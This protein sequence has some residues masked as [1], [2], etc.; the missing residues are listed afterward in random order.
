MTTWNKIGRALAI[1]VIVISI[2]SILVAAVGIIGVWR[3]NG[4]LTDALVELAS[5]AQRGLEAATSA[6]DAVD[7]LLTE[8]Q[9]GLQ[10]VQKG[11]EELKA[12]IQDSTPIVAAL[13]AVVGEDITPKVEEAAEALVT[14]RQAARDLNSAALAINNLPFANIEGVVEATQTFI[15][16]FDGIES[17]IEE[18]DASVEALKGG[19]IEG[20][21]Q[22]VQDLAAEAENSLAEVQG[23]TQDLSGRLDN[24]HETVTTVKSRIPL[25]IDLLSLA[26]TVVLLWGILAQAALIYLCLL[27]RKANRLDLHRALAERA[28]ATEDGPA[29]SPE[30]PEEGAAAEGDSTAE[31]EEDDE[32]T[33][34]AT[35]DPEESPV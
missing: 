24:A 13:S 12:G 26:L 21:V 14:I 28:G 31:L 18:L 10:E 1:V 11:T 30:E 17:K 35:E 2:L 29:S 4:P 19:V 15:D 7:P 34:E 9:R 23:E 33:E 25:I 27:Y 32:G 3:T 6:L 8:L 22:P 5:L 20:A 16:L